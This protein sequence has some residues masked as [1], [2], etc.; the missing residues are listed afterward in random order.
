MNGFVLVDKRS[1]AS[2]VSMM[3]T[4]QFGLPGLMSA[5]ASADQCGASLAAM[6]FTLMLTTG[7]A[8]PSSSSSSSSARPRE[9]GA[10]PARLTT[11]PTTSGE[12]MSAVRCMTTFG[13]GVTIQFADDSVYPLLA[14]AVTT[15]PPPSAEV[16]RDAATHF[17][18]VI[19]QRLC[20]LF[21]S[22]GCAATHFQPQGSGPSRKPIKYRK[23][24][25]S[26]IQQLYAT[27]IADCMKHYDLATLVF[28]GSGDDCD[29]AVAEERDRSTSVKHWSM[30][31]QCHVGQRIR[32]MTLRDNG[33][34]E[35]GKKKHNAA[36]AAA[37]A[38]EGDAVAAQRSPLFSIMQSVSLQPQPV[39]PLSSICRLAPNKTLLTWVAPTE[40]GQHIV[41]AQLLME[42]TDRNN[43]NTNKVLS[44][45]WRC[46]VGR[47]MTELCGWWAQCIA[48]IDEHRLPFAHFVES[49][50]PTA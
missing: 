43:N 3:M 44:P 49:V 34:A 14:V 35:D 40:E 41:T 20:A 29:G 26:S 1:G 19:A 13:D 48:L 37:P 10:P 16:A 22:E 36:A 28:G 50:I 17:T 42:H 4:P 12:A 31:C 39:Q 45:K 11:S 5:S 8:F 24:L 33:L 6:C 2:L 21:V 47:R 23:Q 27:T 9:G 32:L 18:K 30:L 15:V 46:A 25:S 7:H 38:E